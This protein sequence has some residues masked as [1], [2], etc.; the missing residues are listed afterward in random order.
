MKIDKTTR[1]RLGMYSFVLSLLAPL[2]LILAMSVAM[3]LIFS[4][5][6]GGGGVGIIGFLTVAGFF[7]AAL[8]W[9]LA[10]ILGIVGLV[11]KTHKKTF[12][13]LGVLISVVSPV[14]VIV[15]AGIRF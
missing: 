9:V 13:L 14:V 2:L 4:G 11:Q 10:L 7:I 15:W 6:S 8:M 1:A 3:L 5:I 12:A